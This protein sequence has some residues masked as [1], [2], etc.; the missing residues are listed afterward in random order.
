MDRKPAPG[1][2]SAEPAVTAAVGEVLVRY[3]TG[4]DRRDWELFRTCF[5]EDCQVDYGKMPTGEVLQWTRAEDITVWMEAAHRDMGHTLHRITNQRVERDGDRVTACCYVDVL[6][7]AQDGQLIMKGAGFY[8]D[9][10]VE[11]T[12]GWKI[13]ERQFIP[14]LM[15]PGQT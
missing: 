5:T 12:D 4:I 6:L 10:L 8:N 14:V 11:T 1:R 9:C 15:R 3:A 7:T 13:A 2:P